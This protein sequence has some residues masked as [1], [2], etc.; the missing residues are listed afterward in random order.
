MAWRALNE[1]DLLEHL[2]GPELAKLRRVGTQNG[3]QDPIPGILASTAEHVRG[4]IRTVSLGEAG[5][6]PPNLIEV[7]SI[8]AVWH[9]I[10]WCGAR[11]E[12]LDPKGI[13]RVQ[14]E[15]AE[16]FL[17]NTVAKGLVAFEAPTTLGAAT[18]AV[19]SPSYGGRYLDT[20]RQGARISE[21]GREN[22]DG[23]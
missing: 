19:L 14:H 2:S 6:L 7:A 5:T 3:E 8:I 15:D 1:D 18:Y 4:F 16:D 13:R 21:F 11:G 23:I 12:L 22:E 17:R 9:V 10:S 20:G